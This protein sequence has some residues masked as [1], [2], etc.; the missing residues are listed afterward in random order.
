MIGESTS[1]LHSRR[2]DSGSAAGRAPGPSRSSRASTPAGRSMWT[3]CGR[4][5]RSAS[6]MKVA[7][8][9]NTPSSGDTQFV[10]TDRC[11]QRSPIRHGDRRASARVDPSSGW[12]AGA[13]PS[14]P[15]RRPPAPTTRGRGRRSPARR[16]SPVTRPA[17]SSRPSRARP[18]ARR[19]PPARRASPA[20]ARGSCR[21]SARA[22]ARLPRRRARRRKR[23]PS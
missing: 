22:P 23:S 14:A 11:S 5:R 1:V 10:V 16:S 19:H 3:W 15:C 18:S 21:R 9:L 2:R 7:A 12:V 8:P 6:V 17:S 4:R 20:T 13:P